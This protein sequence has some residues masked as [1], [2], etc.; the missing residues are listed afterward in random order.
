M[1]VLGV[2]HLAVVT[3]DLARSEAFYLGVLRLGLRVR[4]FTEAGAHRATWVDLPDGSFLA[5][6]LDRGGPLREDASSG[7]HC[8]ALTID[9]AERGAWRRHLEGAG[10]P[11]VRETRFTLY[12]RDPSGVLVG[13][14]HH[15]LADTA[16]PKEESSRAVG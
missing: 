2:H 11:V 16:A 8:V 6:E 4:H 10:H 1:R 5:L 7:L 3:T 15:P 12:V 14:S 9:P 13:L